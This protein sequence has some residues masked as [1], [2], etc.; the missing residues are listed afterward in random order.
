VLWD[1]ILPPTLDKAT[2]SPPAAPTMDVDQGFA[3]AFAALTFLFLA[4][5][6]LR[7]ARLVGDP[8]SAAPASTCEEEPLG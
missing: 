7:C 6:A 3:M 4:A 1:W 2:E 5:M 8:Y